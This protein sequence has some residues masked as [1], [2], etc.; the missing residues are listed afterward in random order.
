MRSS[1]NASHQASDSASL[2]HLQA[3]RARAFKG[4]DCRVY[5]DSV[6]LRNRHFE[7]FWREFLLPFLMTRRTLLILP[8]C[9]LREL[10][11]HEA[12]EALCWVAVNFKRRLVEIRHYD[13]DLFAD[14][15]FQVVFLRNIVLHEQYLITDDRQLVADI[16]RI[17]SPGS[18]RRKRPITVFGIGAEGRAGTW[19]FCTPH[20]DRVWLRPLPFDGMS[21]A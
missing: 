4:H 20:S 2:W 1:Y 14:H 13:G 11:N 16:L 12:R 9:I 3:S 8:G 7:R 10:R 5:A 21:C 18:I 19:E 15:L 17:G 6:S